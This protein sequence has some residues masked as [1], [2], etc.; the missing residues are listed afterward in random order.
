MPRGAPITV[1]CRA[2][3]SSGIANATVRAVSVLPFQATTM[4]SPSRSGGVGG[5]IR[6]GRPVSNSA[7]SSAAMLGAT[8]SGSG[9]P[10]TTRSKMRP[11]LPSTGVRAADLDP[12]VRREPV[13]RRSARPRQG[14]LRHE[15]LEGLARPLRPLAR[16]ALEAGD[17]NPV[18]PRRSRPPRRR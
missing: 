16:L 8:A 7:V 14:V 17:E 18:P 4:F 13:R 3:L 2:R 5:A 12:P 15:G 10:T 9:R 1:T 11:R 6:S